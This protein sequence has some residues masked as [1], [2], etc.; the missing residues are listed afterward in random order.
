MT[1]EAVNRAVDMM[2]Q[3]ATIDHVF[4]LHHLA[5]AE[6]AYEGTDAAGRPADQLLMKT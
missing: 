5:H 4:A 1:K 6:A 3:R 2:G